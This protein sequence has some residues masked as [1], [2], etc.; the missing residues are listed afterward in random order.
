MLD[1]AATKERFFALALLPCL[2]LP[3]LSSDRINNIKKVYKEKDNVVEALRGE[4]C[5]S[6]CFQIP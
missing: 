4:S 5:F 1:Q 6:Q 2:C 3:L